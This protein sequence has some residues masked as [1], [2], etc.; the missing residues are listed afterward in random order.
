[1]PRAVRTSECVLDGVICSFD[2][3]VATSSST[4]SSSRASRCSSGRGR[5]GASTSRACS[6]ITSARCG[7]RARTTTARRCARRLELRASA[8]WPSAGLALSAGGRER[9][10]AAAHSLAHPRAPGLATLPP[11]FGGCGY[12]SVGRSRS[13]ERDGGAAGDACA[14][15]RA[16]LHAPALVRVARAAAAGTWSCF[17]VQSIRDGHG[18]WA[19]DFNGNFRE[20]AHEIL[21]GASPYHPDELVRVKAAVAAGHSPIDYDHGVF[22]AYPAP[23]LLLGV[24]FT[25][26]PYAV[27]AWLWFGCVLAAGGLALR[28]R[29]RA[30]PPGV[31]GG[32][33]RTPRDRI[34]STTAPSTSCSCS[35]WRRAGA[36]G[37]TRDVPDLALGAIVALKLVA[38]PLVVW[39]VATRRWRAAAT[40]LAVAGMLAAAGW[41]AIGFDGLTGYPHLLSLLTDIESDRGYSAVAF[42]AALGAGAGTAAWA[43]YAV[44]ACLLAGA[45]GHGPARPAGADAAAFLLGVLAALALSPIVWQHSLALLLVPL[46]VLRPRFGPLWALPVA[47]WLAPDSPE[48]AHPAQLAVCA[49]FVAAFAPARSWPTAAR[50][51]GVAPPRRSRSRERGAATAIGASPALARAGGRV[52]AIVVLGALPPLL[53]VVILVGSFRSGTGAWAIDFNGNFFAPGARHPQRRLALPPRLPRARAGARSTPGTCRTSSA[54]ACSPPTRRRACSCGVPFSF[55]PQDLAE[56]LWAGCMLTAGWLALRIVGVRDWRVYGAA[57]LT[58]AGAQLGPA[59]GGRLRA[60]PRAGDLLALARSRGPR[61][62]RAG[63]NRRAQARRRAARRLA[64]GHPALPRRARDRSD[65]GRTV[66][67]RLGRDRLRRPH[68][69]SASALGAGGHR[70]RPRLLAGGLRAP[71][72]DLGQRRVARALRRRC[73]S[74]RRARGS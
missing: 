17:V 58:P 55:L 59:R 43:P 9:R 5:S 16:G 42:A 22:A 60:R 8:S 57:L 51:P 40:S 71:D 48:V 47:L 64:P 20:P 28:P 53:L 35:G 32:A 36:G 33:A 56:W 21:R 63:R 34:A 72:R 44:G 52:A 68:R 74:A 49:A 70:G 13:G 67:G 73:G 27:A 1:M 39:L 26:L 24:P 45:L 29:R 23:G 7:S 12:R 46:A 61:R 65:R 31:R 62:A 3:G 19:I 69:L 14:R 18:A 6:T 25:A 37:I 38:L 2:E 66:G 41:A 54:T 11:S 50:D 30:R 15:T 4:C 10:L